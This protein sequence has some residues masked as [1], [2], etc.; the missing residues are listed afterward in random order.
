[1]SES[2]TENLLKSSLG[3]YKKAW[4]RQLQKVYI[5]L[6][7]QRKISVKAPA[8][9]GLMKNKANWGRWL[10]DERRIVIS[11]ELILNHPWTA[12]VGILGHEMAHQLVSE[13]PGGV[14]QPPHGA[15]FRQMGAK[16]GLDAFYL[17]ASVDLKE[18]FPEPWPDPAGKPLTDNR[19]Q[20]LEKVQKLLALSGS[21][22]EAEAQAAMKAA[23][24]LMA[25]HNLEQVEAGGLGR[26]GD[27]E[28]RL[29]KIQ[30]GRIDSRL[31]LISHIMSRHF[32]VKTLFVPGYDPLT[33]A[34]GH[35]L[36]IL[37]RPEN[38]RL[39]E[40]VFHFLFERCE[41]L[42][43]AYRRLGRGGGLAARNSFIIGLLQGFDQKLD[44]AAR[45]TAMSG[46]QSSSN[47]EGAF[48][49]PSSNQCGQPFTGNSPEKVEGKEA[50]GFS[51][52]VLARDTGLA[53]YFKKRHPRIKTSQPGRR[54][55]FCPDSDRAGREAGRTLSFNRPLSQESQPSGR[56]RFLLP[57]S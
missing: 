46:L 31:G 27:Y 10:P 42:W 3:Q 49:G 51:A 2:Q 4:L 17:K 43:Q 39:A 13:E 54:R 19:T 5:N 9:I 40:H 37:G 20:I 28:Y 26:I 38:T 6:L 16:L 44:E 14:D 7:W 56:S 30:A 48:K 34:E 11:E 33:N 22:V 55:R 24:K 23:A 18:D 29:I 25:R 45:S 47:H 41:S 57:D 35:D 52:L 8:T 15:L 32:F 12:V 36:E 21:P 53:D 50:G 1:M